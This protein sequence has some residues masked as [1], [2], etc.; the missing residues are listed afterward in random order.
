MSKVPA[1][2]EL[3]IILLRASVDCGTQNAAIVVAVEWI[4]Q[5]QAELDRRAAELAAMREA[6]RERATAVGRLAD[7]AAHH[8]QEAHAAQLELGKYAIPRLAAE[9]AER[10]GE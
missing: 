4:R 6:V 7:L 5:A 3:M 1:D 9:A 2:S 8:V 10:Q